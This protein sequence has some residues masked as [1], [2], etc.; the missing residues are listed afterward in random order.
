MASGVLL[1]PSTQT[2]LIIETAVNSSHRT[3]HPNLHFIADST[4][5]DDDD[6]DT[7]ANPLTA[8]G[9]SIEASLQILYHRLGLPV[10][11]VSTFLD[12]SEPLLRANQWRWG[13]FLTAW[14]FI[15]CLL[16][17]PES[18]YLKH[19]IVATCISFLLV[20][21]ALAVLKPRL[22]LSK[23]A[24]GLWCFKGFKVSTARFG[25]FTNGKGVA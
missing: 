5:T 23:R 24:A 21:V 15:L 7:V 12:T 17:S 22:S 2:C 3:I 6:D 10:R 13:L 20:Y 11:F 14:R 9:D 4:N 16:H 8:G 18:P 25:V 19:T 1:Y